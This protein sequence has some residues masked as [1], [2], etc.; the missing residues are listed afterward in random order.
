MSSLPAVVKKPTKLKK[1]AVRKKKFVVPIVRKNASEDD[2]IN[3]VEEIANQ[4]MNNQPEQEVENDDTIVASNSEKSVDSEERPFKIVDVADGEPR[5]EKSFDENSDIFFTAN[6]DEDGKKNDLID[7]DSVSETNLP[8]D[9]DALSSLPLTSAGDDEVSDMV[10]RAE[11][12][13]DSLNSSID[14]ERHMEP[15]SLE[16]ILN[17][18]TSINDDETPRNFKALENQW[19]DNLERLIEHSNFE[20]ANKLTLLASKIEDRLPVLKSLSSASFLSLQTKSPAFKGVKCK[21]RRI[22][23]SIIEDII[24]IAR[25]HFLDATNVLTVD[26]IVTKTGGVYG[27]YVDANILRGDENPAN[28]PVVSPDAATLQ[29]FLQIVPQLDVLLKFKDF[30]TK[31]ITSL[32][33]NTRTIN[34]I[35]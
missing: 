35:C 26:H 5:L 15:Q 24:N 29:A 23:S 33:K 14:S 27:T 25:D 31:V 17:F 20:L 2:V 8:S 7:F 16:N 10:L 12:L 28:G 18:F 11:N 3:F 22:E 9:L 4:Q 34:S 1:I 30:A 32:R 19:L 6:E 13:N 21:G